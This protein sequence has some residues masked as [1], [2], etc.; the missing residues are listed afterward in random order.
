[1]SE[2]AVVGH[3]NTYEI[4]NDMSSDP[5]IMNNEPYK[6]ELQNFSFIYCMPNVINAVINGIN[7]P[8]GIYDYK[9]L[10]EKIFE[11]TGIKFTINENIGRAIMENSTAVT[12]SAYLKQ[13]GF[14]EALYATGTHTSV[15]EPVIEKSTMCLLMCDQ[16]ENETSYSF[17]GKTSNIKLLYSF[18][19]VGKPNKSITLGASRVVSANLDRAYK[20]DMVRIYLVDEYLEPF[21]FG[22]RLSA[23]NINTIVKKRII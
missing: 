21:N 12:G 5:F 1:M 20:L 19:L 4:I 8:D 7:I 17:N 16:L 10:F 23:F 14:P 3:S 9:T 18:P 13:L 15:T 2:K 6:L 22:T 11:L